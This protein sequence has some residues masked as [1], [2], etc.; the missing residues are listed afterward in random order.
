MAMPEAFDGPSGVICV[1]MIVVVSLNLALGFFGYLTFGEDTQ[2]CI[3]FNLPDR[4]LYA[5]LECIALII[6][7]FFY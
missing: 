4:E 1:G 5:Y 2:S 7:Y 6:T 3:T